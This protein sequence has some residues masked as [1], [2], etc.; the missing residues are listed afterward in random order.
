[1]SN[2]KLPP[3]FVSVSSATVRTLCNQVRSCLD[4]ATCLCCWIDGEEYEVSHYISEKA[5]KAF[6]G[7]SSSLVKSLCDINEICKSLVL[8]LDL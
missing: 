4:D 3:E 5:F 1:M 7:F 6:N 8:S 2:K